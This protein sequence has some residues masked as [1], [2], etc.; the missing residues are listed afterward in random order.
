[1]KVAPLLLVA[2]LAA[3]KPSSSAKPAAGSAAPAPAPVA[4]DRAPGPAPALPPPDQQGE[5]E[6][7]AP[8]ENRRPSLDKNG[9]GVISPEEREQAREERATRMRDR[10]DLNHDGKL[11]PDEVAAT[12][13]SH[14]GPQFDDPKA[15]DTNNDGEISPDE[16]QAGMRELR[17]Q[18]RG[19]LMNGGSD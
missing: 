2:S 13:S 11:T 5:A 19:R 10:L 8:P 9:D 17:A 18:R 15:L 3:C 14:R 7:P 4:H 1:M 12:G 6:E 16:L